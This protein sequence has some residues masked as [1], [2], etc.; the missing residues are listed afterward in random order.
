MN[1]QLNSLF[2]VCLECFFWRSIFTYYLKFRKLWIK[3]TKN[4]IAQIAKGGRLRLKN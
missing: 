3:V 2:C 1:C 4:N